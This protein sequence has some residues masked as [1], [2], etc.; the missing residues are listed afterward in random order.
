[1]EG[2]IDDSFYVI[3]S[4]EV[5]VR[6]AGVDLRILKTGD[7]FGEMGYLTRAR[8]TATIIAKSQTA[9]LKL[10][11]TVINQVSMVCQVRFLKAFLRTLIQRLS[12]TT[13]RVSQQAIARVEE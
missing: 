11:S 7:C 5:T 12:V 3:T 1:M 6:K 8:R 9:L 13:E 2:E 4:G 10:N